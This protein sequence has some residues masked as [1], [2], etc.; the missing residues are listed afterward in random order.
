MNDQTKLTHDN[1][2]YFSGDFERYR[3]QIDRRVIYTPGVRFVAEQGGAYWLI[4]EL[5]FTITGGEIQRAGRS[6]PRILELHF[7]RLDVNNNSATLTARAD[8]DVAPFY[9]KEIPFTD[10][11][12]DQ[13]DIWAAF[14][15]EHWT[16]YLPSEH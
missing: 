15:G 3:H 10:F 8:S 4:D 1:L 6:D 2:R 13:I 9:T 7:W 14:D 16:L 12:L 5:A 11:P